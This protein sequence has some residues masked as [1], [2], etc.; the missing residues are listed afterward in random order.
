MGKSLFRRASEGASGIWDGADC[1]FGN[2]PWVLPANAM[3]AT[4][5]GWFTLDQLRSGDK[6][7]T[8]D[9]GFQEITDIAE[10]PARVVTENCPPA[11]WPR[12]IP[13]GTLGLDR[14]I[15][16]MPGQGVMVESDLAEA[17]C[18]DPFAVVAASALDGFAGIEPAEP[19]PESVLYSLSFA[20]DQLVYVNGGLLLLIKTAARSPLEAATGPVETGYHVQPPAI[21]RQLVADLATV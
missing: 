2:A 12:R 17:L 7:L 1:R 15:S 19:A 14:A 16:V 9:N 13:A 10:I 20:E 18:R 6:V 8:F 3:L 4:G 21:A 5:N 11:F